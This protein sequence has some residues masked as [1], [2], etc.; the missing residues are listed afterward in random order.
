MY[1]AYN[2]RELC[3]SSSGS[4]FRR[5][6]FGICMWPGSRIW[7]RMRCFFVFFLSLSATFLCSD[8]FFILNFLSC[9]SGRYLLSRIIWLRPLS[10]SFSIVS[11]GYMRV[12]FFF[13]FFLFLFFFFRRQCSVLR[14][15]DNDNRHRVIIILLYVPCRALQTEEYVLKNT[16]PTETDRLVTFVTLCVENNKK[17]KN[18]QIIT[19]RVKRPIIFPTGGFLQTF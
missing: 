17:K 18:R 2:N 3:T 13:S 8:L 12:I 15:N 14:T 7:R 19:Y 10:R 6:A 16:F 11:Y 9:I 5:I 4:R 1:N